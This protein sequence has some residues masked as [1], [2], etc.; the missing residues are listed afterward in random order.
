MSTMDRWKPQIIHWT[1]RI[2]V[3]AFA[4]FLSLFALDVFSEG[5]DFLETLVALFMHLLP[6][7][8]ILIALVVAWVRPQIGGVLFLALGVFSVFFFD[9]YE[10]P[11]SFLMISV[12]VF[13]V[14]ALFLYDA[15]YQRRTQP[16][17]S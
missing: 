12:P 1:P 14:G 13:V 9:T 5:Y 6:T 15:W 17:G 3:I 7:F 11:I 8:A 4:V 10:H 16:Q 2:A